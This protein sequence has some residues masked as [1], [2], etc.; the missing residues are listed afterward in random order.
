MTGA[1]T[2]LNAEALS[3]PAFAEAVLRQSVHDFKLSGEPFRIVELD[4]Q[5]EGSLREEFGDLAPIV[6]KA[7][8]GEL[9]IF[10]SRDHHVDV[11]DRLALLGTPDQLRKQGLTSSSGES[12]RSYLRVGARF[13]KAGAP[14]H[15]TGSLRAWQSVFY[16][17]DRALKTTF[18]LF[19]GLIS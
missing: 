1:G 5:D 9:T 7:Q 17:A 19:I 11:G 14:K 2:V 8:D 12:G 18:H 6:A 16:G 13:N 4:A 10:P 3:A 15:N